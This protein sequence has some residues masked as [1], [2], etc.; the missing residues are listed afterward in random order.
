MRKYSMVE[1]ITS[2]PIKATY[3]HAQRL[4]RAAVTTTQSPTVLAVRLANTR[5]FD[6]AGGDGGDGF[7]GPHPIGQSPGLQ[8]IPQP[9]RA[10]RV[11]PIG[12]GRPAESPI[13]TSTDTTMKTTPI[14]TLLALL[15][16][17]TI[18][19]SAQNGGRPQ[20]PPRG[21]RQLPPEVIAKFDTDGDGKLSE[22]E[23]K[24]AR[25]A[26]RAEAEKRREAML[27]KY[28]TDGDG[29]LSEDE[30]AT[31]QA[32]MKA[33]HEDLLKKYDA[34]GDGKLSPEERKAAIDAGEEMPMR[35]MRPGGPRGEGRG[36]RDGQGPGPRGG[37]GPGPRG[38]EG[39]PPV[40]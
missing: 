26:F 31:L 5:A 33:R 16:G 13:S 30:R 40:E 19:A 37:Q 27:A 38:G 10:A 12:N 35:P 7:N 28:D 22:D 20:G 32:D 11:C 29:K 4:A 17:S 8:I 3:A 6:S 24:A 2:T 36:P 18:T 25:E 34:D 23:R 21:D 15:A 39:P 14:I 1:I 9:F